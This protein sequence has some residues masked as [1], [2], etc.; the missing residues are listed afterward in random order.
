MGTPEMTHPIVKK[1]LRNELLMWGLG[2]LVVVA[3]PVGVVVLEATSGSSSSK[4]ASKSKSTDKSKKRTVASKPR[5]KPV[6]VLSTDRNDP[7]S[8]RIEMS[9]SRWVWSLVR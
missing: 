1:L 2:V 8:H 7:F 4:K 3:L 9:P 5:T 6:A